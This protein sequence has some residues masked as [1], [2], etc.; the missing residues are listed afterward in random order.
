MAASPDDETLPTPPDVRP[1]RGDT[2][3][4]DPR[5]EGPGPETTAE[6]TRP[7][8]SAEFTLHRPEV[9]PW[10]IPGFERMEQVGRGGMGVVYRAW[11]TRL[12]RHVALKVLPPAF[13]ADPRRFERFRREGE[14]AARLTDARIVP[15]YDI[16]D[17]GGSP[18]L[19]M[20]FVEGSDL[21][22][23]LA[24]RRATLDGAPPD[25]RHPACDLDAAGYLDFILPRLDQA[26]ESVAACHAEKIL[27]R[28]I[29]PPNLM[30]DPR[31]DVRLMD[32]GLA[33]LGDESS[34]TMP[35]QGLG[36]MGYMSPEQWEGHHDIDLRADVFG[37]G[38]TLYHALTLTLPYGRARVELRTPPPAPASS[39]AP[40][41]PDGLGHILSKALEPDRRDRYDSAIDLLADWRSVRGGGH[42]AARPRGR[43]SRL[44]R[45]RPGAVSATV[46][47][48]ALAG[49]LT[50]SL[51][52]ATGPDAPRWVYVSAKPWAGA[53]LA[54]DPIDPLTGEPMGRPRFLEAGERSGLRLAPG[55]YVVE[56]LW[57]DGRFQEVR[58]HVPGP[59]EI[60]PKAATSHAYWWEDG[61]WLHWLPVDR[62][63]PDVTA[64]MAL[65]EGSDRFAAPAATGLD[66]RPRPV[67]PFY[68]DADEATIGDFLR[69]YPP[70]YLPPSLAGEPRDRPIRDIT[71]D[72][73]LHMAEREGKTLPSEAQHL[74]ARTNGGRTAYP[75]GDD[76]S[77]FV[78]R[79]W[80]IGPLGHAAHDATPT[81][82][83]VRGLYSNV[84]EFST[85]Y[86]STFALLPESL[87]PPRQPGRDRGLGLVPG[88]DASRTRLVLGIL[89]AAADGLGA[90]ISGPPGP[91]EFLRLPRDGTRPGVGVRF[92]RPARPRYLGGAIAAQKPLPAVLPTMW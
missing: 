7:D 85:T 42:P 1:D 57:P 84:G 53:E 75:W 66:Q 77:S 89:P 17:V 56:A 27:H 92:A 90:T 24:D 14:V 33:R 13:A 35:G 16:L 68:L 87:L 43:V 11:Q 8:G 40:G 80:L 38:A 34:L 19:V 73:A 23:V 25:R 20:P 58:R 64:G 74:F 22:R 18:V 31:G 45:N 72:M 9:R 30:V 63:R 36:S 67:R 86:T 81:R 83:P 46:I 5:P 32:F 88:V 26:I 59:D 76:P 39:L 4:S 29:K 69:S 70:A 6:A 47:I 15:I 78:G 10:S 12:N 60:A 3:V 62:P 50:W 48:L 28:D 65:F 54:V 44:V 41:L 2:T 91:M 71:Y 49:L 37:L 55:D 82:P 61:G 79:P 51:W 21:G 52:P